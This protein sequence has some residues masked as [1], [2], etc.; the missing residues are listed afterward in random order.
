MR[1]I[2]YLLLSG[3][4]LSAGDLFAQEILPGITVKNFNGKI[5]VSWRN[6]YPLEVRTINIQRSFDSLK[7]FSTIGTVLTPQ[8]AENGF[9]DENPPYNKMYYRLFISFDGGAYIFTDPVR[10]V[11][12]ALPPL[13][14]FTQETVVDPFKKPDAV[15]QPLKETRKEPESK[16]TVKT[17]PVE[18]DEKPAVTKNKKPVKQPVSKTKGKNKQV[19]KSNREDETA[20]LPVK[21]E[22]VTYPSRRIYTGRDNNI[23]INLPNP[24]SR[25]YAVKFFDEED[26]FMFELNRIKENFLIIEKVNFLHAG[27]FYFELFENGKLIEK[28][29][30][31]IPRDGKSQ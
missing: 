4:M 13:P 21:E 17:D 19:S 11:K 24:D 27:W 3:I 8:N 18:K 1:K 7:N 30:F 9:V 10:P 6:Q 2:F 31:F 5:I 15:K 26:K 29:K 14:L 25:R 28:N 23:V 22:P 12:E 16:A 20:T